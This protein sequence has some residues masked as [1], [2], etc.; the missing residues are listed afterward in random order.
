M[1]ILHSEST[2]EYLHVKKT[3]GFSFIETLISIVILSIV[4][5]G[6]MSMTILSIRTNFNQINHTKAVKLAEEGVEK[7]LREEFD[8]LTGETSAFDSIPGFP[9]FS[10]E[11]VVSA[12]DGD[13][14]QIS[15][16]V[17]WIARARSNLNPIT[18]SVR[19]TRQ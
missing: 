13:N 1:N 4:I 15:V 16:E 14:I 5:A 9:T 10:R 17:T 19:R 3:D 2:K 12:I 6:V 18:L 8:T 11:I 7:K